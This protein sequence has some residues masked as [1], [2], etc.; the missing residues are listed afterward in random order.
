MDTTL[1]GI[2]ELDACSNSEVISFKDIPFETH[3]EPSGDEDED[4]LVEN[5]DERAADAD[6]EEED[7]VEN[8]WPIILTAVMRKP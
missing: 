5:E 4:M 8:E 3:D 7:T 6:D 2:G 1:E